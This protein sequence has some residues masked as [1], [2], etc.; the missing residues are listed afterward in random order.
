MCNFKEFTKHIDEWNK[1]GIPYGY[2]ELVK[3]AMKYDVPI[4]PRELIK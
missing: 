1:L 3:L 4:I 2:S